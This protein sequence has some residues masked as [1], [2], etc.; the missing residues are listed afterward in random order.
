M[1]CEAQIALDRRSIELGFGGAQDGLPV[2]QA[3][4]HGGDSG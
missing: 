2:A 1:C 3:G 4:V